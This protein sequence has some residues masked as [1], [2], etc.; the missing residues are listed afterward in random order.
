MDR[1]T[2]IYLLTPT[3]SQSEEGVI[4]SQMTER[5]IYANVTSVT[6]AEWFEGGRNGLNPELRFRVFA[7]D[8]N[9]EEVLKYNDKYYAI[10][11]TYMA[12]DDVLELYCERRK[13]VEDPAVRF[14]TSS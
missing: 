4:S 3:F 10:Y 12:R 2:P 1:S 11:R 14:A 13:G 5:M 6:G 7:P 8:Y 9:G